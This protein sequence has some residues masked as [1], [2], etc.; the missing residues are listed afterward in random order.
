MTGKNKWGP[1]YDGDGDGNNEEGD[2]GDEDE[3]CDNDA[4][5]NYKII[6][7]Q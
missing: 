2:G 7:H 6:S 5:D 1:H 4:G 3:D